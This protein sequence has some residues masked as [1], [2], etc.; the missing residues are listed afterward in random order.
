MHTLEQHAEAA[1]R[2]IESLPYIRSFQNEVVVIKYGGHA[3]KEEALKHSFALNVAMLKY[4]GI[5]PVVVH[6]G[7]PQI[8]GMLEKLHIESSFREGLRVTDDA[9]MDVVEMVL[10]GK[11]NQEIVGRLNLVGA[12]AV[13]LSGKDG[14]LIRAR[15]MEMVVTAEN[16]PPEIIDLGRVGEVMH[17]DADLISAL[18][19]QGFVPVIAPTGVDDEGGTY[20]INADAVAGAVA[21]ALKAKRLLLLTDVPGILNREGQLI[22]SLP[23]HETWELF[24]DG[25]IQGGMIPKVKCCLEALQ[26]GVGKA[27]IIDGRLENCILLELFTDAGIGTEIVGRP[28]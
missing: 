24:A 4:L 7:G 17:V 9:T 6:G 13:G 11:V 12:K 16:R 23:M 14:R 22:R 2:L 19:S 10:V 15:R 25:T 3:M 18:S 5:R 8:G 21:S 28:K 20:N 26:E 27:M 1:A